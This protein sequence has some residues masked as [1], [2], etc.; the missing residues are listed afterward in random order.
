MI[1]ER[2]RIEPEE[3]C[4]YPD[5]TRNKLEED[6][7]NRGEVEMEIIEEIEKLILNYTYLNKKKLIELIRL[8]Y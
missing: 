4:Y 1:C 3:V 2:L 7:Y 5:R 8:N 6:Y